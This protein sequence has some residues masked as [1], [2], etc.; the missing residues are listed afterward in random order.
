MVPLGWEHTAARRDYMWTQGCSQVSVFK[1]LLPA[2]QLLPALAM[3]APGTPGYL[4]TVKDVQ[5]SRAPGALR[6]S[7]IFMGQ[8]MNLKDWCPACTI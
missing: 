6:G 5:G 3:L 8:L 1:R 7:G 2:Q 4:L